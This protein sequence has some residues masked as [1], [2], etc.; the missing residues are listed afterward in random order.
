[1]RKSIINKV[2]VSDDH[3]LC[4]FTVDIGNTERLTGGIKDM[5]TGKL[6]NVRLES[7]GQIE[8]GLNSLIYF[9]ECDD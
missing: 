2:K 3:S 4:A 9:T 6:M 8:F 5:S 7:I 1:M